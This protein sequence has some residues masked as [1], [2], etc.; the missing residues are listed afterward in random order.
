MKQYQDLVK[1]VLKKGVEKGDRTG[2]GTISTF[3]YQT[4]FDLS[5]GFPLVT[6][7]KTHFKSVA[8]ELLWF[9]KGDTNIKYLKD[10][11]VSIWDE[12]ADHEGNLGP[13]YGKQW[14]RWEAVKVQPKVDGSQF[15][16]TFQYDQ[17]K[18]AIDTIKKDPNSRRI[19]VSAWNVADLQDMALAPCHAFFQFYVADNKLSCQIYQRSLDT[20]IGGPFNIASYALLTHMIAHCTSLDV[21][22]LIW[23]I[24]DAHIYKNHIQGAKEMLK[25]KPLPLPT[26]RLDPNIRDID[27]F[28]YE[29]I[30]LENYQ[31]HP[32]VKLDVA[33]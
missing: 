17:I 13:V 6:I 7:K 12:W 5:K 15:M 25:R 10:N 20:C 11:G 9:L 31:H 19:I 32:A 16:V 3:G 4:R 29:H 14:R 30:T 27:D 28:R 18:L 26:I 23:T 21:G 1:H 2:T 33:V 24:G 8:H 22:E